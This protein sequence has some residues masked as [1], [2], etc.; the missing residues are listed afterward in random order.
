[1]SLVLIA[2]TPEGSV[3]LLRILD[4]HE[5]IVVH[6][7]EAAK[8]K[9][10]ELTFDLIIAAIHFDESH[11]FE[12]IR[13]V[14]RHPNNASKPI[15]S[16]CSRDTEMTRVL[17][18]SLSCSTK[19]LGAWMYLNEHA[20]DVYKDPDAELRRIMERCLTE[21]ARKELLQQ[22][23]DIQK[24]R[25]EIQQL[26]VLLQAQEWSPQMNDYLVGLRQEI[27]LLLQQVT[28]LQSSAEIQRASV[29]SSRDQ[30]D[31]VSED[32]TLKENGMSKL[33]EIQLQEEVR[34]SINENVLVLQE[35]EKQALNS[36]T[37]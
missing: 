33:E 14:S 12:L 32:V 4:G 11:M 2:D 35:E 27:E 22:R 26:R 5:L 24:Q 17:H 20:Y 1:M 9:L 31:R 36:A 19:V 18:E 30:K 13:E 3:S 37:V 25:S 34:Q 6:T 28:T 21:E 10:D 23:V 7:L 15:I 8:A 29:I 16:F